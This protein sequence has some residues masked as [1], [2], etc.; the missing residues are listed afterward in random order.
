MTSVRNLQP[1]EGEGIKR[2]KTEAPK[3]KTVKKKSETK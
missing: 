2:L 1:I 3:K